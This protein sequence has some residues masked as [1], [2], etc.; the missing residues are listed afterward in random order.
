MITRDEVFHIGRF[1]K[2]HGV[3]GEVT[4]HF[5]DDIF[6]N[7]DAEYLILDVDGLLVPF[8]M[9][10]YRFRS[11]ETAILKFENIDSSER[12]RE[13]T[14]C[15]VYYKR[16]EKSGEETLSWAQIIGF[17]IIDHASGKNIGKI[18]GVD[19]ATINILFNVTTTNGDIMLP[20]SD[21]LIQNVDTKKQE[22]TMILPEGILE[23]N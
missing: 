23:L 18:T 3:K 5:D 1:L 7:E 15:D 4:F 22:I 9:E 17:S 11:E 19:D 20:A 2:P 8:F 10:E 16:T 21:D 6:D 14:G 12:A 13:L